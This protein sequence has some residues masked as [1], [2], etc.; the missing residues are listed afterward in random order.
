MRWNAIVLYTVFELPKP[1]TLWMVGFS[2]LSQSVRIAAGTAAAGAAG[3]P[4]EL[5]FA[6]ALSIMQVHKKGKEQAINTLLPL[7]MDF[8]VTLLH[9]HTCCSHPLQK[10]HHPTHPLSRWPLLSGWSTPW[11]MLARAVWKWIC[12]FVLA[13]VFGVVYIWYAI[14][15][16]LVI[17]T[18]LQHNIL[19]TI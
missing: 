13:H 3:G 6:S 16:Q 1:L 2:R 9:W 18:H 5:S 10:Q 4:S 7:S 19:Q 14:C 12:F 17:T 15:N 11:H 8:A